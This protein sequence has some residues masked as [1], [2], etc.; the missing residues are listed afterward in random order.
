MPSAQHDFTAFVTDAILPELV[1]VGYGRKGSRFRRDQLE[2]I[3]L[4]HVQ[5]SQKSTRERVLFAINYGVV[6]RTVANHY[7]I[8]ASSLDVESA[9]LR[10]RARGGL[11][12]DGWWTI[13]VGESR[14]LVAADVIRTLGEKTLPSLSAVSSVVGLRDVWI[15]EA[16][17][18]ITEFQRVCYLTILL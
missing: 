4:V 1:R 7:G 6:S 13:E 11:A 2:T 9:H 15:T 14:D 18:G 16:S 17:P 3:A 8:D 12:P 5:R 10:Q